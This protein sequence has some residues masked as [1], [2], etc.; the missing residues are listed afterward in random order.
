MPAHGFV[1]PLRNEPTASRILLTTGSFSCPCSHSNT[2]QGVSLGKSFDR[3]LPFDRKRQACLQEVIFVFC[4]SPFLPDKS[5]TC[6]HY[7]A[8]AAQRQLSSE[9]TGPPASKESEENH[10]TFTVRAHTWSTHT[11]CWQ[12][13]PARCL[14]APSH[15]NKNTLGSHGG[16]ETTR[17][18]RLRVSQEQ[19]VI[20]NW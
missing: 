6:Q 18:K 3:F 1:K 14:C 17:K 12:S 9:A 13:A 15:L 20:W 4:P 16:K 19:S 10:A 8:P 2:T 5:S 7:P 11:N